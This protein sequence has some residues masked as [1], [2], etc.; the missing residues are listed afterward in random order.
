MFE[1]GHQARIHGQVDVR[2]VPANHA[3]VQRVPAPPAAQS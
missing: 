3:Q 2:A 1:D